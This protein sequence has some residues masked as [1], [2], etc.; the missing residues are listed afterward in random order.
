MFLFFKFWRKHCDIQ[1]QRANNLFNL[2]NLKGTSLLIKHK[3]PFD[4]SFIMNKTIDLQT[5][6]HYASRNRMRLTSL[7]LTPMEKE[8]IMK[9]LIRTTVNK[10][11]GLI[12]EEKTRKACELSGIVIDD[13]HNI[14]IKNNVYEILNRLIK[15][16]F[17]AGGNIIIVMLYNLFKNTDAKLLEQFLNKSSLE[18]FHPSFGSTY[19]I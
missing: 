1:I 19:S 6:L 4:E 14:I 7:G 5:R 12:S 13:R 8:F 16:L 9:E 17:I 11:N 2:L 18:L 15:D 10:S 3:E